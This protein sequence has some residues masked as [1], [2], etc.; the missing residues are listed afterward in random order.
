VLKR[1]LRVIVELGIITLDWLVLAWTPVKEHRSRRLLVVRLDGLGDAIL[2]LPSAQ[3]LRAEYPAGDY[4]LHL[5]ANQAWADLPAYSAIFDKVIPVDRHR[6]CVKFN[7]RWR[8]LMGLKK[9]GYSQ[10]IH[11]VHSR[12]FIRGDSISLHSRGQRTIGSRGDRS[13]HTRFTHWLSGRWYDEL[14]DCGP[15]LGFELERNAE[16]LRKYG[17]SDVAIIAPTLSLPQSEQ[18]DR[19]YY[20]LVPGA[21]HEGKRW[22]LARF[23]R[24]AEQI[25]A[26][27]GWDGVICGGPGEEKL[28]ED[29]LVT[30][31]V[32]LDNKIG[33]TDMLQLIDLVGRAGLVVT[34]DT[35][36]AHLS[37]ALKTPSV[38][39]LGGWHYGRYHPYTTANEQQGIPPRV[40]I[41]EMSCFGCQWRCIFPV[42]ANE[43]KPCLGEI[44]FEQVWDAVREVLGDGHRKDH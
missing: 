3:R 17:L 41:K 14:Y 18:E 27:T 20:L 24:L 43:P 33:R 6:F 31:S 2:W 12:E 32:P 30:S 21:S 37:S 38:C 22:P 8:T 11:P 19:K 1:L 34:N 25:S 4:E 7:Y 35:A 16:F 42:G 23:A 10:V 40:V 44:E 5:V 9:S 39:I 15:D 36:A 13:N 28:G 26:E 29:L